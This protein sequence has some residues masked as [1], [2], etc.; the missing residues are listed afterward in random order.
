MYSLVVKS[1]EM[2]HHQ[3]IDQLTQGVLNN[4]S[5]LDRVENDTKPT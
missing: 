5:L 1:V 4:H 3:G 2:F